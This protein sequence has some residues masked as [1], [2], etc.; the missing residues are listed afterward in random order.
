MQAAP[1]LGMVVLDTTKHLCNRLSDTFDIYICYNSVELNT[2]A[3]QDCP[4]IR[5]TQYLFMV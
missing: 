2:W 5:V 3:I 4:K 1:H